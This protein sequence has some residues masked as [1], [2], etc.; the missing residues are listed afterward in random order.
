MASSGQIMAVGG[1]RRSTLALL[2]WLG[3]CSALSP[4]VSYPHRAIVPRRA[5]VPRRAVVPR[6]SL[7]LPDDLVTDDESL[8]RQGTAWALIF[9]YRT[10]NEGIYSQQRGDGN[11]YIFTWMTEED[12]ERYSEMLSAQDF[13]DG[14]AVKMETRELLDFCKD[15][16][17]TLC[18]VPSNT[19]IM[20]PE[21]NVETFE[22]SPGESA[23]GNQP[24][25]DMTEEE[26]RMRQLQFEALL[27][28]NS[29]DAGAD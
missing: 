22:W 24:L 2:L 25:E 3:L 10:E 13:P 4:R 21:N 12:A 16:G 1:A 6:C 29:G 20:P 17:H 23:E 27:G 28:P 15:S 7:P 11:E 26:L 5:N 18:L 8:L 14:T 9:N 19:V